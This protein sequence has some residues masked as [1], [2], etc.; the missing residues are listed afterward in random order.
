[1]LQLKFFLVEAVSDESKLTH[2]EHAEDH[3]INAGDKGFAHAYHNLHDVHDMLKGKHTSTTVTTKYDGSPSIVWGHHPENKKFF[4]GTKSVFNK[5]PKIN[6]TPEDIDRNH[7]HAPGLADKLKLALKHLPKI[8]PKGKIYQ[9][10]LMHSGVHSKSNPKGD[11]EN[12]NGKYHFKP[13]TITYSTKHDSDEGKKILHSKIGV[14]PHTEYKGKTLTNMKAHY[15]AKAS[16]LKQ[17]DDVHVIS[18]HND[19]KKDHYT[20]EQQ[21]NFEHHIGQAVKVFNNTD[22]SFHKAVEPHTEH[23]K[24]YINHTVKTDSSP[25]V[26]GYKEHLTNKF[27][28]ESEKLKTEKGKAGKM[29]ELAKHH[30][31]IES[32]KEHFDNTLSMHQ[33]LAAAKN[34]LVHAMSSHNKFDHHIGGIKTKPEGF[35][36]VRNN[37]PTKLVDR[38]DFS[39]ANFLAREK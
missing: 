1:M 31:H 3:V 27:T 37:R 28:K 12:K 19:F 13:N 8:T 20:K 2:L 16:D 38:K 10:D 39:R 17:H 30:N 7:G 33:H 21:N 15:N 32:N 11:V 29:A 34:V 14:V 35:V 23:L 36:A 6:H 9:G 22:K 26:K 18:A 5:D 24:Q 25:S 4:V